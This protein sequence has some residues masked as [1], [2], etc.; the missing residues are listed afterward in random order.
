LWE[1]WFTFVFKWVIMK[2][3]NNK[4]IKNKIKKWKERWKNEKIK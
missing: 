2:I 1:S 3:L 4:I